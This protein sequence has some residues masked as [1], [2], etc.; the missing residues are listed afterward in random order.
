MNPIKLN[1]RKGI[2][3]SGLL[4]FICTKTFHNNLKLKVGL[5]LIFTFIELLDPH[6]SDNGSETSHL[7]RSLCS[8]DTPG[9]QEDG[10]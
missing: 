5:G 6:G 4:S 7:V 10:Q 9:R 3:I 1:V 8:E 2:N